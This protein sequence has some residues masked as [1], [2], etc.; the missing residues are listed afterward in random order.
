MSVNVLDACAGAHLFY[1]GAKVRRY[2]VDKMEVT[3]KKR[4]IAAAVCTAIILAG[5]AG[6]ENGSD[7]DGQETAALDFND[8]VQED[9]S[10]EGHS[11]NDTTDGITD[12]DSNIES[13]QNAETSQMPSQESDGSA[14]NSETA[15]DLYAGFIKNEVPVIIGEDYPQLDYKEFNLEPG[16]SYTFS[17]LGAFVNATHFNS[18]YSEKTSYDYAQYTYLDCPDSDAGNL[19]VKFSGL[20]IYSLNDDSYAVYVITE[21][22][23]Q[24]YLTDSYECWARSDTRACKNGL[25]TLFGS[26]GAGDHYEGISAVLTDGKIAEI[27]GAEILTGQWAGYVGNDA[28]YNEVFAD[29]MDIIFAVM[30]YTIGDKRLY[31]YDL[32]E[33]TDDQI[34]ICETYINRCRDEVGIEWVTEDAVQEAVRERCSLLGVSYDAL[35]QQEEAEWT[36]INQVTG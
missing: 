11:G 16:K 30:I 20:E 6:R 18:E 23:G 21:K 1:T 33:C 12:N 10:D 15:Q 19:L 28:M 24:L 29:N 27:Y 25:L 9:I 14:Q 17:E 36:E 31:T 4:F 13:P 26:G 8:I 3:M 5:C 7:K 34:S 32:S 35:S 2:Q 22:E